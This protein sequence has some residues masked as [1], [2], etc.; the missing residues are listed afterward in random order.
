LHG[1]RI[2]REYPKFPW[3]YAGTGISPVEGIYVYVVV[4]TERTPRDYNNAGIPKDDN[5]I[6]VPKL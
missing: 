4:G 2:H 5:I 3:L 6:D 1:Q